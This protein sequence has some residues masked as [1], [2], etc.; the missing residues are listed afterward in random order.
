[1]HIQKVKTVMCMKIQLFIYYFCV[2][3]A[4]Q[5]FVSSSCMFLDKQGCHKIFKLPSKY[6]KEA[7]NHT[8]RDFIWFYFFFY[9]PM[10]VAGATF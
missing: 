9:F 1:M 8:A 2:S 4:E 3:K 5:Y 7:G 6:N 10:K